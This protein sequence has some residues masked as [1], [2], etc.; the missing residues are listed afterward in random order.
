MSGRRRSA[1]IGAAAI[2]LL[3]LAA[4]CGDPTVIRVFDGVHTQGRFIPYE[5]YAYYARGVDAEGHGDLRLAIQLYREAGAIDEKSAELWTR[6]G[7]AVCAYAP[8]SDVAGEAF[9]RAEEIDPRYEPLAR[10]RARCAASAGRIDEALAHAARAVALDP[11]QDDAVVLQASLLE[12]AGRVVDAERLLDALVIERPTSIQGWLARY[13]LALRRRDTITAEHAARAL[14]QRSPRLAGR[15]E[16]EVRALAP[17]AEVDAALSAG[18]LDAAR[19]AARHARLPSPEL[20]VRAAALG[21]ASLA[22]DQ[23]ALVL[24]ADPSSSSARI[25]LAVAADLAGDT[26]QLAAALDIP[27]DTVT[28]APSPLARLLFADL[29]VRRAGREAARAYAGPDVVSPDAPASDPLLA[30]VRKRVR[31]GLAP[32]RTGS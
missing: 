12:R 19:K 20:A 3:G 10:A 8:K 25:A 22:R 31:A 13:E 23:A 24:G 27:R 11:G 17:L 32:T 29:L 4:G 1:A 15:V 18:N 21:V 5:A 14:R 30:S 9:S 7:A 2:T 28:V 16:S 26:T 6:L